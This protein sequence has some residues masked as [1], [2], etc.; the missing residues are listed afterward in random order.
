MTTQNKWI[1]N[2]TEDIYDDADTWIIPQEKQSNKITL[3][4]ITVLWLEIN[5]CK[6]YTTVQLSLLLSLAR[7]DSFVCSACGTTVI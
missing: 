2:E 7:L 5:I 1:S 6:T 3:F 4:K